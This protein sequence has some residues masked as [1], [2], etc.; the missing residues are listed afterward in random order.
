MGISSI[1]IDN[2]FSDIADIEEMGSWCLA[3]VGS[4]QWVVIQY[5]VLSA[6][7]WSH[8]QDRKQQ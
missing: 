4:S 1:I 5:R 2:L 8:T 7:K 3:R 6:L